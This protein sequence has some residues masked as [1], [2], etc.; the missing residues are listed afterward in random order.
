MSQ[1]EP[2]KVEHMLTTLDNPFNPFTQFEQWNQFDEHKG[3]YT[4]AY[5]ARVVDYT[6]C[7]TPDEEFWETE[8]AID[9]VVKLNPTCIYTKV[10][11]DEVVKPIEL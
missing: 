6:K 5:L 1:Q 7:N 9:E 3:Y 8:R 2:E 10:T 4:I 11:K